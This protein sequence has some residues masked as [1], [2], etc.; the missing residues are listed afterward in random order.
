MERQA[1]HIRPLP[2]K[3]TWL[4]DKECKCCYRYSSTEWDPILFPSW[5]D[6][7]QKEC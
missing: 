1:L 6:K 4:V 5:F 7:L 3:A 2:R